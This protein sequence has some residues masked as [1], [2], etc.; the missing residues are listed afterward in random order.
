MNVISRNP[1]G[2]RSPVQL[3]GQPESEADKTASAPAAGGRVLKA[4]DGAGSDEADRQF[5]AWLATMTLGLSPVSLF[6]A[7]HDWAMHLAISPGRQ[8]ANFLKAI[9]SIGRLA[10]FAA[11]CALPDHAGQVCVSPR[12]KDQ[13]FKGE[14]WRRLPYNFFQ[15]SFLLAEDWWRFA[16][17]G[18]GGVTAQH[19]RM[20]D[21]FSRQFLDML[22]PSNFLL[23]NPEVIDRTFEEGGANLVRGQRTLLEYV[24]EQ[25]P[26]RREPLCDRWR[27][28]VEVAATPGDVIYRNE[29]IELIQYSPSTPRVRQEPV[30]IVPAWIM[31]YYILDLA[32]HNSLIRYLVGQG[33]TVFC[34]SWRNPGKE[35]RDLS[36]DDYRTAGV[37]AAIKAVQAVTGAQKIHATG[38]CLGGTLL[39]IAAA[40]MAREKDDRIAT[41]SLFAAQLDFDEPGELG[42]FINESQLAFLE[43]IM[44]REGYLDQRRMAGAFQM[45]RSQDLIWSRL[46]REVLMGEKPDTTDLMAWNSDTTRMPYLMQSQYLRSMYLNNDLAQGRFKVGGE[47]VLVQDVQAPVFA[48]GTETDHVAP[49][50]SVFK[51]TRMFESDMTFVLTSG[52]HNAGIIS[53]PGHPGR[54]FRRLD[55]KHGDAHPD[56]EEWSKRTSEIAGSW[57]PEWV[58]WLSERSGPAVAHPRIGNADYRP[59][60]PA[61]GTYVLQR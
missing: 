27:V 12:P 29:L 61:P 6:E 8:Q 1:A 19:E 17:T 23:T 11:T 58:E 24:F 52:G 10:R 51:E 31:K 25:S 40:A 14:A 39:S 34:I 48:V 28:G 26:A 54:H 42:L 13:R 55:I 2:G 50:Q 15:Q 20:V 36:F 18:V 59:L 57:W 4:P 32:P 56:A 60:C 9:D 7:W 43:D 44:W 53:E 35:Q 38:Y 22:A 30:L 33:F 37:M 46:V 3:A 41:L 21:F 16:A 45:L 5:H 47:A 49:W